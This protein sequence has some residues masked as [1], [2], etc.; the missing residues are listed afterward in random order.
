MYTERERARERER[1]SERASERAREKE[2]DFS[3]VI[4]RAFVLGSLRKHVTTKISKNK[5]LEKFPFL[6]FVSVLHGICIYCTTVVVRV[7][8]TVVVRVDTTV[9]VRVGALRWHTHALTHTHTH[10][11]HNIYTLLTSF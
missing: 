1:A 4:G 2:R 5:N 7:D 8:K 11:T 9:V 10:T 6:H 3:V